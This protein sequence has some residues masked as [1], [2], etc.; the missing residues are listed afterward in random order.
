MRLRTV[1]LLAA[2]G[3]IAGSVLLNS[4]QAHAYGHVGSVNMWQ[5]GLSFNCDNPTVCAG[6]TGGFWG[7]AQF[8]QDP[9]TG[10]T[11]AD[12]ELAG[13]GHTIAGGGP[14]L[15]GAQHFSVDAPG[16]IIQPSPDTGGLLT[17]WLTTG[18]QTFTGH[19]PPVTTPLLDNDGNV[20]TPDN[21]F[22]T[23]IPVEAGHYSMAHLFGVS[24][25][26]VSFQIQVAYKPAH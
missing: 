18:E 11:D 12:A 8:T 5:A 16:W 1:R 22:D 14:G 3:L 4:S 15:A 21:P 17:F 10:E 2:L 25:P 19:G 9:V 23:G 13:C 20:V 24:I 26:G 6:Q 7:W